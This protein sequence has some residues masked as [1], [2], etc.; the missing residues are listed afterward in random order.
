MKNL[1]LLLLFIQ[2]LFVSNAQSH[3]FKLLNKGKNIVPEISVNGNTVIS[4]PDD[5]L[6]SVATGW[7]NSWP[8][9]WVHASALKMDV[10]GDWYILAGEINLPVRNIEN[11]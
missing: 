3:D 5:G 1:I 6:W 8:N 9:K 10:V 11:S 4:P 2:F 7:S